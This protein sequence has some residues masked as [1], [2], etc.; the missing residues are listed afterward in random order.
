MLRVWSSAKVGARWEAHGVVRD[1]M[2]GCLVVVYHVHDAADRANLTQTLFNR[3]FD[4][5]I[6]TNI[7]KLGQK[8][9]LY[10]L[11]GSYRLQM[12]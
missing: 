3:M 10:F 12:I 2:D 1:W 5:K 11:N 6:S 8:C 4:L 7:Y 9:Y